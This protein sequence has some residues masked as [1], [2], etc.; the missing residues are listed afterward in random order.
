MMNGLFSLF[1]TAHAEGIPMQKGSREGFGGNFL[2]VY[3]KETASY[4]MMTKVTPNI[5]GISIPFG[6][7]YRVYQVSEDMVSIKLL[8]TSYH[9]IYGLL[10]AGNRIFYEREVFF[11]CLSSD[12]YCFD[13]ETK[14]HYKVVQEPIRHLLAYAENSIFYL[15]QENIISAYS[16]T[17]G[18]VSTIVKCQYDI[19][20]DDAAIYYCSMDGSLVAYSFGSNTYSAFSIPQ[21][22]DIRDMGYGLLV[23]DTTDD[24]Y[25][26]GETCERLCQLPEGRALGLD[27]SYI[28]L[29]AEPPYEE[30]DACGK[31]TYAPLSAPT[32]FTSIDVPRSLDNNINLSNGHV[33][34]YTKNAETISVIALE[35]GETRSIRLP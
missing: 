18:N 27:S 31:L 34:C 1:P 14:A 24:L 11:D 26:F 21:G 12:L 13:L 35:T 2:S 3:S 16:L 22:I 5:A 6:Y 32:Q 28:Y 15:D 10:P 20:S 17:T 30:K 19:S 29:Y 8:F 23:D 33:F 9:A 25:R 7:S 4:Y